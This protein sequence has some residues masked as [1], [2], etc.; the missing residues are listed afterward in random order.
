[1]SEM[2][3]VGSPI[4]EPRYVQLDQRDWSSLRDRQAENQDRIVFLED[5]VKT[6]NDRMQKLEET[7]R[8]LHA[9]MSLLLNG[10]KERLDVFGVLLSEFEARLAGKDVG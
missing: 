9:Q 4:N 8:Q 7:N 6:A 1:M 5:A 2:K 10:T 3:V